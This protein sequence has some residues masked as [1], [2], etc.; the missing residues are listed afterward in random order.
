M[1]MGLNWRIQENGSVFLNRNFNLQM[2]AIS[3]LRA[4][5]PETPLVLVLL[6]H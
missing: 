4:N 1:E 5:I 6:I 3:P 2:S